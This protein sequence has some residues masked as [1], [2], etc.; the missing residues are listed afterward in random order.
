LGKFISELIE[1][2]IKI[3]ENKDDAVM[4]LNE[5]KELL[6]NYEDWFEKSRKI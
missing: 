6:I 3:G 4:Y 2:E 5:L 1:K